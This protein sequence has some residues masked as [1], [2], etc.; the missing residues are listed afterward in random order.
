MSRF[1]TEHINGVELFL[2]FAYSRGRAQDMRFL[3]H[4]LN[5][6]IVYRQDDTCYMTI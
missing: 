4:V 2:D 1:S 5:V 3:C 6:K